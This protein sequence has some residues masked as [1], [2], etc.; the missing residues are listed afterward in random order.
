VLPI[1]FGARVAAARREMD[2]AK[3]EKPSKPSKP[4]KLTK[5]VFRHLDDALLADL[6]KVS[7]GIVAIRGIQDKGTD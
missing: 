6:K 1:A 4:E 2:M 7:G 5:T 3:S